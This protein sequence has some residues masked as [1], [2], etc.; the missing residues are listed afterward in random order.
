MLK[1]RNNSTTYNQDGVK[2][3]KGRQVFSLKSEKKWTIENALILTCIVNANCIDCTHRVRQNRWTWFSH[4]GFAAT[5]TQYLSQF[6]DCDLRIEN[7]NDEKTFF[8][9]TQ[10]G[11]KIQNV[12]RNI[13]GSKWKLH[14]SSERC[15]QICY[16]RL[17]WGLLFVLMVT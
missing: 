2:K 5:L 9:A 12:R 6:S 8:Y 11:G 4:L 3:L 7:A 16:W 1:V 10:D 14:L 15:Y 13:Y 17:I